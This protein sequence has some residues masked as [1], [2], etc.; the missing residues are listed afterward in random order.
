MLL[1]MMGHFSVSKHFSV[2]LRTPSVVLAVASHDQAYP[3]EIYRFCTILSE[4]SKKWFSAKADFVLDSIVTSV[5][6]S[7]CSLLGGS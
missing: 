3:S 5:S 6:V 7:V 2:S 1:S 4:V